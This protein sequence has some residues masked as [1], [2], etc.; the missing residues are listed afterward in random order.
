MSRP[1]LDRETPKRSYVIA[2]AAILWAGFLG[3]V[4][5]TPVSI[6]ATTRTDGGLGI[7]TQLFI[8]SW[9]VCSVS[10]AIA[11]VLAPQNSG[12]ETKNG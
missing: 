12:D 11:W 1:S 3:A 8:A 10:A 6:W 9:G 7:I 2:I 4:L 5:M